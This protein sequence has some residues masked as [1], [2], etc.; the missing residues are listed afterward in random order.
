MR[1]SEFLLERYFARWE[2]DCKYLLC[3]SGVEGWRMRDLLAL[4]SDEDRAA[5]DELGLGYTEAAGLPRLREEIAHRYRGVGAA[6]IHCFAGAEE[7]IYML[8]TS[9]VGAGDHVVVVRPA[10]QSL[11]EIARAAG[12]RVSEVWLREADGWRLDLARI[13]SELRPETRL[14]IVNFPHNPTGATIDRETQRA[15]IAMCE[16]HGCY[17]LSDEVYRGLEHDEAARLPAA[18]TLSPRAFSLGAMAKSYGL[19]GLRIG[20]LVIRDEAVLQ[21]AAALKDYGSMCN[22]APSELL[23][24]IALRAEE[25]VLARSQEILLPNLARLRAFMAASS[26][27]IAWSPPSGG[28]T[29]FPRLIGVDDI[30]AFCERLVM[31]TGVLLLPGTKYGVPGAHVR[32]GMGRRDFGEGLA[33]FGEFLA[34]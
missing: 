22:A 21:R 32:I 16:Q 6:Q 8:V 23:A 14:V 15:L 3:A 30:D 27:R 26:D 5:W 33:R 10:Y 13:A 29:A 17:L 11:F 9:L 24:L 34:G 18:V 7:A 25:R 4:A 12:A 20:W 31:Q 2:F 19:P 28:V 1:P